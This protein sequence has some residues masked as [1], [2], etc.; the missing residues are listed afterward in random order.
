M[1][2]KKKQEQ[3]EKIEKIEELIEADRANG[4]HIL[5]KVKSRMEK[6]GLSPKE[7]IRQLELLKQG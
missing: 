6:C 4:R 3:E 5:K 7:V 1:Q 2:A